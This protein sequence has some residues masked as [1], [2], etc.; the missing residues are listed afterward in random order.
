MRTKILTS[1][2]YETKVLSPTSRGNGVDYCKKG[3]RIDKRVR[4]R[5]A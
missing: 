2:S 3:G 4:S 1:F 5:N